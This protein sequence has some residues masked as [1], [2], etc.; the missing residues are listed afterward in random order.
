MKRLQCE[1]QLQKENLDQNILHA[2]EQLQNAL[3]EREANLNFFAHAGQRLN[4]DRRC[5]LI[6]E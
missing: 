1:L 5:W 3:R 4:R 6:C 2:K